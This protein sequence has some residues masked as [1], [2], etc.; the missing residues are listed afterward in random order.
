[1]L[2]WVLM[3][4][5]PVWNIPDTDPEAECWFTTEIECI[6]A[7]AIA[8]QTVPLDIYYCVP[9]Y[10]PKRKVTMN[11][12]DFKDQLSVAMI[13]M[14]TQMMIV[15]EQPANLVG[16][17]NKTATATLPNPREVAS[18]AIG[19]AEICAQVRDAHRQAIKEMRKGAAVGS[20]DGKKDPPAKSVHTSGN[21]GVNEDDG[22][23]NDNST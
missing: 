14:F 6:N 13:P 15:V 4:V 22:E 7:A 12:E 3:V 19:F 11:R 9:E 20:N 21:G 18:R 10:I 23:R 16:T 1:M 2:C 8:Y 5:M 17:Q